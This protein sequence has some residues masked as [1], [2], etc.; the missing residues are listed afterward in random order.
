MTAKMLVGELQNAGI[1]LKVVGQS[2]KLRAPAD[3]V[4][5]PEVLEEI[6][7]RKAEII[8][9]LRDEVAQLLRERQPAPCASVLCAGCYE[10]WPA[11]PK[12]HPPKGSPEW[13]RWR[14]RWESVKQ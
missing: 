1:T 4:P 2:L 6:R 7:R 3:R 11:G 9:F 5:A 10:L 8:R 14:S 13:Q 12:I